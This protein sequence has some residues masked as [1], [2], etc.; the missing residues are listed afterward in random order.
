MSIATLRTLI[1]KGIVYLSAAKELLESVVL[2]VLAKAIELL[3]QLAV[4]LG[5]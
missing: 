4:G 1:I 3:K 5:A 2:P